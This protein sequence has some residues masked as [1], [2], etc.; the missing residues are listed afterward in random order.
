MFHKH[1][2]QSTIFALGLPILL[3]ALILTLTP[4]RAAPQH[5]SHQLPPPPDTGTPTGNPTP[6]TTRPEAACPAS[7]QPLT[8]LMANNGRDQTHVEYPTLWFYVPY[9]ATQIHRLEFLLLNRQETET[10]YRTTVQMMG[11]QPGLIKVTLPPQPQ[12]ALQ[13]N[14]TYRWYLILDCQDDPMAEPD[15]VVDGWVRRSLP[16][17]PLD[18]QITAKTEPVHFFY[19]DQGL[20]YDAIHHV[21]QQQM[22]RPGDRSLTQTWTTLLGELGH[23]EI[24]QAPFV[25]SAL[26]PP[27]D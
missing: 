2:Q 9:A 14:Q 4:V 21:A 8:A 25:E 11:N 23:S 3:E 15:R 1:V 17:I 5:L 19:R 22:T 13:P 16:D 7:S 27:S 26:L 18:V 20:W 6:G 10:I 24:A 12:Y